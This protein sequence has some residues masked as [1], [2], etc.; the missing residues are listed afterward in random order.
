LDPRLRAQQEVDDAM[1]AEE[2]DDAM[3]AE[4]VDD[5]MKAEEVDHDERCDGRH[6]PFAS[7]C[8]ASGRKGERNT[9]LYLTTFLP[10][11]RQ[12][13][14]PVRRKRF[15]HENLNPISFLFQTPDVRIIAEQTLS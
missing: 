10:S 15:S 1:K 2:V 8:S 4:E 7:C 6:S 14:C 5:A 13:F 3:K 12:R 9:F 11:S